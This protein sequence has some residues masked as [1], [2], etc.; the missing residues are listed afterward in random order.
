MPV[1][2]APMPEG[3]FASHQCRTMA[4]SRCVSTASPRAWPGRTAAPASALSQPAT[5]AEGQPQVYA[6]KKVRIE[7]AADGQHLRD[8]DA[9]ETVVVRN[10]SERH[11]RALNRFRNFTRA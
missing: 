6:G 11:D 7:R 10:R 1:Q 5:T 4:W 3:S 9:A 8:S 2:P